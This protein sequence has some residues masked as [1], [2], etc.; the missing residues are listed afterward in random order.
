[1]KIPAHPDDSF[2]EVQGK[3]LRARLTKD[4][5]V[6]I[7]DVEL[8]GFIAEGGV[9]LETGNTGSINQ[10]VVRF[11]VGDVDIDDEVI[12]DIDILGSRSPMKNPPPYKD[13][14]K[15]YG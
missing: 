15:N 11:L 8:P 2:N 14:S 12:G 3:D 10:L 13:P 4:H 1:M 5:K 7:G 6:F 9:C